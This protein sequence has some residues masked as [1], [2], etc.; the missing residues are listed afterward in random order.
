MLRVWIIGR[1]KAKIGNA[2]IV[3][4]VSLLVRVNSVWSCPTTSPSLTPIEELLRGVNSSPKLTFV[5]SNLS[6]C[7]QTFQKASESWLRII[8][9]WILSSLKLACCA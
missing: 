2:L 9:S 3:D 4:V 5:S 7:S 6:S 1:V 8:P